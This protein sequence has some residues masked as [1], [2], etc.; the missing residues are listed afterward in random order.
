MPRADAAY[1]PGMTRTAPEVRVISIGTLAANP[2]WEERAPVRTGHATTTLIRS[3]DRVI[4]VDPGLPD[5][6]VA[7]RLT[8]RAGIPASAVTH[9]FLTCFKPDVFRGILAFEKAKW[10]IS[11]DEREQIGVPLVGQLQEAAAAGDAELKA[12]LELDVGILRRCEPAPDEIAPHVSLFPLPGATPGLTGLLIAMPG[13]GGG[14]PTVLIA[15][16]AVPTV[17]HLERGMVLDSAVNV[18]RARE[19][20]AE[21]VEIADLIVPGRD[22][23]VVNPVRGR[24]G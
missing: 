4:L 19:S 12:A 5:R 18:T 1:A 14:G 22:N 7:A 16:D 9:V 15:G 6:A 17:E 24:R 13:R 23:L 2:L 11:Q 20:F 10:W 3:G 21:A 8:E